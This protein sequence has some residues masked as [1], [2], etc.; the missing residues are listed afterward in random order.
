MTLLLLVL[1]S[2]GDFALSQKVPTKK[3]SFCPSY[4]EIKPQELPEPVLA[5]LIKSEQW[6]EA[7][8]SLGEEMP[9]PKKVFSGLKIALSSAKSSAD[10]YL[11]LSSSGGLN[12]ADSD[13]FWIVR[14]KKD[15]ADILLWEGALCLD[16]K[17]TSS[18]GLH[19]V[20]TS[21]NSAMN[22]VVF[23][24]YAFDGS[25]YKLRRKWERPLR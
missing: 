2:F 12:G 19:D 1:F 18:H 4:E 25:E 20:V 17:R 23:T 24:S 3:T 9:A 21:W 15:T 10:Y 14:L 22:P 8:E 13:S 16:I 7:E 6:K 11:V 5:P